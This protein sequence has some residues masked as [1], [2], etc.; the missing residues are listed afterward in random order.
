M[1]TAPASSRTTTTAWDTSCVAGRVV[2]Q[3]GQLLLGQLVHAV[4]QVQEQGQLLVAVGA[5]QV[6]P[7]GRHALVVG[8]DGGQ[9]FGQRVD[10]HPAAVVGVDLAPHVAGAFQPVDHAGDRPGGAQAELLAK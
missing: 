2:G 7:G 5:Q 3:A 9:P 10:D 6:V 1:D 4:E 8:C